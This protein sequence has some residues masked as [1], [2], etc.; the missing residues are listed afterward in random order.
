MKKKII[1]VLRE[2]FTSR[3]NV[4]NLLIGGV[5]TFFP[6][7][8]FISLGYLGTK[9]KKSIHQDKS[10]VKWDE[11]IKALFITGFFLFIVCIS[12]L[13]IPFLLMFLGG[14]LMLSLSQGKIFS[15]FYFRGQ[16]LNLLGTILLLVMLYFLP[17]AVC[18]YLEEDN[19][20]MVFKLPKIVDKIL[21]V[22]KEYTVVYLIIIGLF[23][24]SVSIIFLFMNWVTG[25]LLSGFLFFYDGLVIAGLLSKVFP[26]KSLTISLLEIK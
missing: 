5:I 14:S 7:F 24:I 19:I 22:V 6:V 16:I 3:E 23:T 4:I 15:L 13:I 2:P 26:R 17:F 25:L 21:L 8:N 12:Y 10:P 9:L 18:V 11:N 20:K 1:E